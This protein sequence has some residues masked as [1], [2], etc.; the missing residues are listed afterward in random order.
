MI[1]RQAVAVRRLTHLTPYVV[2]ETTGCNGSAVTDVMLGTLGVSAWHLTTRGT[3]A[4]LI[5]T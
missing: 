2:I 5:K 4:E 3:M 1:R